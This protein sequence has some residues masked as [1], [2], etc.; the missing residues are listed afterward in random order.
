VQRSGPAWHGMAVGLPRPGLAWPGLHFQSLS[1]IYN[2][3]G[4]TATKRSSRRTAPRSAAPNSRW[5]GWAG[6]GWVG[7][8]TA[9]RLALSVRPSVRPS[10]CLSV[11]M[12]RPLSEMDRPL[13][14][15]GDKTL[16]VQHR[17]LQNVLGNEKYT[18]RR[19]EYS[20]K[21]KLQSSTILIVF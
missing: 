5:L 21:Q 16:T 20:I 2:P 8:I 1:G 12:K 17:P 11:A 4:H 15:S 13:P 19:L 9:A 7:L 3:C 10:A 6:L 18:E 14:L